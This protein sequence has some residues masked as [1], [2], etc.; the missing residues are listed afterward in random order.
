MLF[1]STS[2]IGLQEQVKFRCGTP[3]DFTTALIKRYLNEGYK[4]AVM[5][6]LN[7]MGDWNFQGQVGTANLVANQREYI[8]PSDLLRILRIEAKL[9]GTNFTVLNQIDPRIVPSVIGSETDITNRFS[10][11]SGGAFFDASDR[12]FNIYSGTITSVTDGLKLWYE[13][14]IA[15]LSADS[16]V[17]VLEPAFHSVL[18][19]YASK[20]W[21][22]KQEDTRLYNTLSAELGDRQLNGQYTGLLGEMQAYYAKRQATAAPKIKAHREHME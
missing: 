13:E 6:V 11:S 9:D 10:N 2:T 19:L 16:D 8:F 14:D 20:I 15:E 18:S 21:A 22:S 1:S 3:D 12:S 7:S 17:P 4:F 5:V